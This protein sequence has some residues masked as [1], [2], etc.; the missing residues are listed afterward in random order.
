MTAKMYLSTAP[1]GP[2][3]SFSWLNSTATNV[4]GYYNSTCSNNGTATTANV[5]QMQKFDTI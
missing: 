1:T 5:T 3:C 4:Y 2:S